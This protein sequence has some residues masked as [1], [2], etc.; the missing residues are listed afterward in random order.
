MPAL[1]IYDRLF[2]YFGG[3][4]DVECEAVEVEYNG[5]PL[6]VSTIAK[7][8]AGVTPVP[9]FTKFNITRFVATSDEG[10]DAIINAW[11]KTSKVKCGVQRGGSGKVIKTEGFV[12]AP[13]MSSGASDHSKQNYSLLCPATAFA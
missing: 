11:I 1:Q 13:K 10:T 5:D 9:K 8:F 12:T 6:P 3:G 4:L 2:F 7:D